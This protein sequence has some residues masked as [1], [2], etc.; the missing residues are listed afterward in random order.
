[1]WYV[2]GQR[3]RGAKEPG[4]RGKEGGE[5]LKS[6]IKPMNSA[7]SLFDAWGHRQGFTS[8]KPVLLKPSAHG[9]T[10]PV[11]GTEKARKLSLFA[12]WKSS[13]AG[14]SFVIIYLYRFYVPV[15]SSST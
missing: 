3:G 13:K 1:M 8:S 2:E 6:G 10:R 5:M 14:L 11:S 7:V 12:S 15:F 4:Q 9:E